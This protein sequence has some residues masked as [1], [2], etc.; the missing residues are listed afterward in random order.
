M[1]VFV[2]FPSLS[3][4]ISRSIHVAAN[5]ILLKA[6]KIPAIHRVSATAAVWTYV[7]FSLFL[8]RRVFLAWGSESR[9]QPFVFYAP[10]S[11]NNISL[12]FLSTHCVHS[13]CLS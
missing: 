4:I 2:W 11:V 9:V 6:E 12:H 13:H 1:F 5:S 8:V 3:M 7:T 10:W